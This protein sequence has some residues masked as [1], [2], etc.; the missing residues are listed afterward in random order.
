MFEGDLREGQLEIGQVAAAI[1]RSEDVRIVMERLRS[2][3]LSARNRSAQNL[4]HQ[5]LK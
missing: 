2:E 5:P 3:Y 4:L 1:S